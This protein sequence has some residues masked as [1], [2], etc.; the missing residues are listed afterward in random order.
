MRFQIIDGFR[1][2]FLFFMVWMHSAA[3]F[4]SDLHYISHHSLGWV[5]D[6]QGFVFFSGLVIGLVFMKRLV[7][8]GERGLWALVRKRV[9]TIYIAHLLV[10]VAAFV[11][12]WVAGA[13]TR[14]DMFT[15]FAQAPFGNVLA[16]VFLMGRITYAD[17]LPMYL[18][19]ILFTPAAL[20]LVLEGRTMLLLAICFALWGGAQTG[21]VEFF[22]RKLGDVSG[23][24]E[25]GVRLGIFFNRFAWQ[26]LYF[27]GLAIGANMA[28]G[29]FDP[30]MFKD[31]KW[32]PVAMVCLMLAGLFAG[33]DLLQTIMGLEAE[34][35]RNILDAVY[36]ANFL[37]DLGIMTW[38]LTA[39]LSDGDA[40][41]RTVAHAFR[42]LFTWRPLV[43][44][45]RH[46]LQV[47]AWHAIGLWLLALAVGPTEALSQLDRAILVVA[48]SATLWPVA[49]LN[50][51]WQSFRAMRRAGGQ[52]VPAE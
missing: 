33:C 7:K 28:L 11:A 17:I 32:R 43:F 24:T 30:A 47:Y 19:F 42:R 5:E 46:S 40:V 27:G 36:V 2:F 23:L 8:S 16:G 35:E 37:A 25:D 14:T 21:V 22:W 15:Y 13:D 4:H 39:G 18:V 34:Q 3:V 49:W 44:L 9:K 41:L 50:A 26:A 12:L 45:G 52:S 6:A 1:G 31:P 38:L 20:Y 29:R 51:R 48:M 10:L